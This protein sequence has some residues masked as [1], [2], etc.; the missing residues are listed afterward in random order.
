MANG[1]DKAGDVNRGPHEAIKT[2]GP[3][4]PPPEDKP[5]AI[6]LHDALQKIADL[7]LEV[8]ELKRK[9]KAHLEEPN[10]HCIL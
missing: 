6:A 5:V 3:P 7:T 10:P 2:G 8:V 4:P 1:D 9:L